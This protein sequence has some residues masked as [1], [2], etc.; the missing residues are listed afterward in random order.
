MVSFPL[1]DCSVLQST[2]HVGSVGNSGISFHDC[3]PIFAYMSM[4]HPLVQAYSRIFGGGDPRVPITEEEW[5][6]YIADNGFP[7]G[8]VVHR[9]DLARCGSRVI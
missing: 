6:K 9:F 3:R 8:D 5:A 7:K 1:R 2:L 4:Y